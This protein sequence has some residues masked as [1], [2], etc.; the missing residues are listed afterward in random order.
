MTNLACIGGDEG[1][2]TWALNDR[3]GIHEVDV[4][5]KRFGFQFDATGGNRNH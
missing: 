5:D 4:Y 1:K 3:D 2:S